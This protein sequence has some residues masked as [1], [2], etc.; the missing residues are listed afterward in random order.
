MSVGSQR[1]DFI[2]SSPP[3]LCEQTADLTLHLG[4]NIC[5]EPKPSRFADWRR[6][7]GEEAHKDLMLKSRN[8]CM[9]PEAMSVLEGG[10]RSPATKSNT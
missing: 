7:C 9:C 4:R 6:C 3:L 5:D 1:R 10:N 2:A 8:L